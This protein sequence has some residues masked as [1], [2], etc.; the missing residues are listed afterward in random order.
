M[1]KR[2]PHNLP[3]KA[4]NKA[5][6]DLN[7]YITTLTRLWRHCDSADLPNHFFFFPALNIYPRKPQYI[8]ILK[9]VTK[10]L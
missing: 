7:I 3:T 2:K 4:L 8:G 10:Q 1:Q 5:I 9:N 6:I